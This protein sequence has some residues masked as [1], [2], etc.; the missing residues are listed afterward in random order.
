MNDKLTLIYSRGKA[1]NRARV[2]LQLVRAPAEVPKESG[3]H[4]AIRSTRAA[5]IR[6]IWPNAETPHISEL[7]AVE[8]YHRMIAIVE[9]SASDVRRVKSSSAATLRLVNADSPTWSP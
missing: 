7:G 1:P 9:S 3:S 6:G 4:E 5:E 2:A 8:S